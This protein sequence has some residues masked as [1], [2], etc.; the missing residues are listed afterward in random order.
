MSTVIEFTVADN[1]HEDI[2]HKLFDRM[3]T[4]LIRAFGRA[5][6]MGSTRHGMLYV[7]WCNRTC[8]VFYLF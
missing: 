3:L 1:E 6:H 4:C 5:R 2:C 8:S 7:P